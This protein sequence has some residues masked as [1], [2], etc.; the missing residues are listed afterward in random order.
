MIIELVIIKNRDGITFAEEYAD[1]KKGAQAWLANADLIAKH[2][3]RDGEVGGAVY[4][5]PSKEAA[6]RAHDD[7]W[8]AGVLKR[9]GGNPPEIRYFDLM[10]TSEPQTQKVTEYGPAV[11]R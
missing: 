9:T 1:A 3:I 11:I 8:R 5:W 6:Q 4:I 10:M 7:K 2:F